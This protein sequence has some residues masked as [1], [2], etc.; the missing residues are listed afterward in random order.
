[1]VRFDEEAKNSRPSVI[2][3]PATPILKSNGVDIDYDATIAMYN[4]QIAQEKAGK[5]KLFHSLV[6]LATELKRVQSDAV[7]L[8]EQA[9]YANRAWYQGGMW[10]PPKVLPAVQ[11]HNTNKKNAR[12]ATNQNQ[13]ARLR[14]AISLSDLFFNLVIV[15]AF[16]RVGLAIAQDTLGGG[17]GSSGSG[18][19]DANNND[20]GVRAT[21]GLTPSTFLYFAIFWT[22]W[23][24]EASY[25]TRFDTTDLSAQLETLVTCFAVLFASL[26]VSAPLNSPGGTRIMIM[27]AFCAL[28]HFGLY[29]RVYNWNWSSRNSADGDDVETPGSIIAAEQQQQQQQQE[30]DGLQN[31]VHRYAAF[32][33]TM[34][35][36]EATNWIL[37]LIF[38]PETSSVRWVV[39]VVGVLLALRIPRAF[40]ANDFHGTS[41]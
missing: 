15:T 40:L 27:A 29:V 5:R 17:G 30:P 24:K 33:M 26:S 23:S 25:S 1:M 8:Q 9:A 38:L 31:H 12:T 19:S 28:L 37:G 36:L 3:A 16:T 11:Q 34:N 39:F 6:K 13:R 41:T 22:I 2:V 4:A 35:L 10:R 18:G 32:N 7:P 21:F 14:E 20:D